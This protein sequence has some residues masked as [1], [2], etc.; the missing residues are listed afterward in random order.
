MKFGGSSLIARC[1]GERAAADRCNEYFKARVTRGFL[2]AFSEV[3]EEV[4]SHAPFW[5]RVVLS[6]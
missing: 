4:L 5:R 1:S 3:S 2:E 6:A